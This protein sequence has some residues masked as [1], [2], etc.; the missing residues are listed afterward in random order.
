MFEIGKIKFNLNIE[1]KPFIAE[2]LFFYP[3]YAINPTY[4]SSKTK[5]VLPNG[6]T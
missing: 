5:K 3:K 1:K 2:W 4:S 6:R